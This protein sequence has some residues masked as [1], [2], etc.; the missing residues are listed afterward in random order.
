MKKVLLSFVF[1]L[2]SLMLFSQQNQNLET[3]TLI[4]KS[5]ETNQFDKIVATFDQTMKTALPSEKL[6]FIWKDILQISGN[7]LKYSEITEDKIQQYDVN[8]VLCHFEN[9]NLKLKLV[10]NKEHQ[11]AGLFFVP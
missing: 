5:F 3:S 4:I 6:Q 2:L 1:G 11:V 7:Y 10:Y 9:L 8:Y